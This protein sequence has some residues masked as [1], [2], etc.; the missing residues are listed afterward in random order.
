M[1]YKVQFDEDEAAILVKYIDSTSGGVKDGP[2]TKRLRRFVEFC[3][4]GELPE[5]VVEDYSDEEEGE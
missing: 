2:L 3:N 5:G 1:K 4:R